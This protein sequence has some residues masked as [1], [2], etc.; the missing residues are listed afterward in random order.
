[1]NLNINKKIKTCFIKEYSNKIKLA[2]SK[3]Y[4]KIRQYSIKKNI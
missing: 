1:M 2:K 3:I 4:D